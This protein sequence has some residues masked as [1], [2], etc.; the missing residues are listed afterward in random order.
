MVPKMS[1]TTTKTE[2]MLA[3]QNQLSIK[4]LFMVT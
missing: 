2:D 3:T 1:I 4:A